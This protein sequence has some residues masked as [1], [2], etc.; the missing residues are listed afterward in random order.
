M[1]LSLVLAQVVLGREGGITEDTF[2]VFDALV[3]RVDV[4]P[5]TSE[6][7]KVLAAGVTLIEH[8]LFAIVPQMD[9]QVKMKLALVAATV[10]KVLRRSFVNL[11]VLP[12]HVHGLWT[13]AAERTLEIL[14][15]ALEVGSLSHLR[16]NNVSV[17]FQQDPGQEGLT[18]I[19]T[20]MMTLITIRFV[21]SLQMIVEAFLGPVE[22][23]TV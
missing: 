18:T 4:I 21:R 15:V 14:A 16:V 17:I 2:P 9:L 19:G 11:H 22:Y 1:S 20:D 5:V 13:V 3:H 23:I 12:Q 10:A 8:L 7:I 6:T